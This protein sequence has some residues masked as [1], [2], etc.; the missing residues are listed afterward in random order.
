MSR[1]RQ[2]CMERDGLD[3][4]FM[5]NGIQIVVKEQRKFGHVLLYED[6]DDMREYSKSLQERD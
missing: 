6:L 3:I 2:A 5:P 4:K 1:W